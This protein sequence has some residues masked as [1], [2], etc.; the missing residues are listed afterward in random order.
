MG[1]LPK[2]KITRMERGKRRSGN[3]PVIKKDVN[4]ATVP[5]SK[6][7][8]VNQIFSALKLEQKK[9]TSKTKTQKA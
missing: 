3:T 4:I 6:K 5:S 2:N 1:A 7:G 8:L 9:A